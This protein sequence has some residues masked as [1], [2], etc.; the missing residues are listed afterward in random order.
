MCE[1]NINWLPPICI[2]H[3][4]V[5]GWNP[6]Q[7]WSQKLTTDSKEIQRI[8]GKYYEQLY[9][10][11]LD[12]VGEWINSKKIQSSK[13]KSERIRESLHNIHNEIE[14]VI[15]KLPTKKSP[16]PDSFTGE[17]YQSS[18]ELTPLF[19]KLF[20]KIPEEGRL[21]NSFYK[22]SITLTPKPD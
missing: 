22:A 1:R 7:R 12:N 16:G 14:A 5:W 4:L 8:A 18:W 3:A 10:N 17:F 20:H 6:K 19:L 21:P 15:K 2:I 9:A 13:T 11:K